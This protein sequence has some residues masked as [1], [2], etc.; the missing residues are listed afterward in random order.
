MPAVGYV[1]QLVGSLESFTIERGG[2]SVPLALLLPV[3]AGDRLVVKGAEAVAHLQCGNRRVRVTE[4]DSPFIVPPNAAPPTF[5]DRLGTLLIEVG[6]RL[7]TQQARSVTKVSTSSRGEE[8]PLALPLLQDR[9]NRLPAQAKTLYLGWT[10]GVPPYELRVVSQQ[11]EARELVHRMDLASQ[12]VAVVLDQP[13]E[14]GFVRVSVRD[15]E[16]TQV[17]GVF[18]VAE[19]APPPSHEELADIDLPPPLR[20]L[21]LADEWAKRDPAQWSL[22]AYQTVTPLADSFEPARLLRDC[23]ETVQTCHER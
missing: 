5:L 16:G 7:T 2:S 23:L 6:R 4:R 10:G 12:R 14:S 18:E 17:Q 3:H 15:R 20:T 19:T 1:E 13:L 11:P 8:D 22:Y 21:L 9:M